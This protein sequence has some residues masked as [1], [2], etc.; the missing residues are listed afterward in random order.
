MVSHWAIN[1]DANSQEGS[2]FFFRFTF[3]FTLLLLELRVSIKSDIFSADFGVTKNE[4]TFRFLRSLEKFLSWWYV[5]LQF[6]AYWCK[7][8]TEIFCNIFWL[9]YSSTVYNKTIQ[10]LRFHFWFT[11]DYC[12]DLIPNNSPILNYYK[13]FSIMAFFAFI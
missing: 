4:T 8:I 10:F 12:T 9:Q 5:F 1:Y 3:C 11:I 2:A 6:F 13:I 7:L